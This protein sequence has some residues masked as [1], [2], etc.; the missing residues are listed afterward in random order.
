MAA[1]AQSGTAVF[2]GRKGNLYF[3]DFYVSDVVGAQ[4][5]FDSGAGAGAASETFWTAPEQVRLV[6]ISI[7]TGLTDTTNARLTVNGRPLQS[8]IRWANFLNTL[9]TRPTMA[10]G[11]DA[12]ARVGMIQAA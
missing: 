4:V 9:A 8:V 5:N 2:Q 1:A 12:N 6:D 11:F 7:V 10:N 3:V